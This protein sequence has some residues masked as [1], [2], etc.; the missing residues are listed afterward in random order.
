M[1]E[2]TH[3]ICDECWILKH[4]AR[5]PVRIHG[6]TDTCCFC[7]SNSA[8]VYVRHDPKELNCKHDE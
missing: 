4:P 3:A 2:W 7:G 1:A 6:S 5:E 8:G